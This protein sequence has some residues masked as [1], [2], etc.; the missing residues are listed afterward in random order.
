[1]LPAFA[2]KDPEPAEFGHRPIDRGL[3]ASLVARVCDLIGCRAANR[4]ELIDSL[5]EGG[6]SAP[7]DKHFGAFFGES[8]GG[9][10]ANAAAP[11]RDDGRP[12]L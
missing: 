1:V 2:K 11:A 3:N 7:N 6:F 5:G 10:S 12:S 9:G 8:R 4:R